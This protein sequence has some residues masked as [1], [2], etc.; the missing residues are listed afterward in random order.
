MQTLDDGFLFFV[1]FF[2]LV[3]FFFGLSL[4]LFL[5]SA[6]CM[7]ASSSSL[8]S[9]HRSSTVMIEE[10][11]VRGGRRLRATRAARRPNFSVAGTLDLFSPSHTLQS[12]M[13]M[14]S[15]ALHVLFKSSPAAHDTSPEHPTTLR[16]KPSRQLPQAILCSKPNNATHWYPRDFHLPTSNYR[17]SPSRPSPP[18]TI[19]PAHNTSPF[20]ARGSP[21]SSSS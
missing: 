11:S 16:I 13:L 10:R 3:A 15:V 19:L 1:A 5:L 2:F 6:A 20:T 21:C 9:A 17:F 18:K 12:P 8:E 4:A 7:A 14:S